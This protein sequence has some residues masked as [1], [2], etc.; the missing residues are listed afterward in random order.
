MPLTQQRP[1]DDNQDPGGAFSKQLR[2]NEARFNRLTQT[3]LVRQDT[4]PLGDASQRKHDRVNLVGVRVNFAAA[5]GAKV[6][7]AFAGAAQAHE[8]LSVVAAV[9]GVGDGVRHEAIAGAPG[10]VGCG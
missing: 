7:S 5:L 3:H 10:I 4:A 6:A 1:R 9:D 2:N 8:V